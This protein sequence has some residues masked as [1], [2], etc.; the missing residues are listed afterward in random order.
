MLE[1]HNPHAD[2]PEMHV[3][4]DQVEDWLDAAGFHPVKEFDLFDDKYFVVFAKK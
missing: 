1:L 3:L 2:V 4:R